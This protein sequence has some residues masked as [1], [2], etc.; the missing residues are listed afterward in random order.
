MTMNCSHV[1]LMVDD[2]NTCFRFYLEKLGLPTRYPPGSSGP[3]AEF[4]LGGDK[5]LGLFDRRLMQEA[6]DASSTRALGPSDDRIALCFEV[7]DVDVEAARLAGLGVEISVPP[8][9][10]VPWGMRTTYVR[11]PAGNLIEL[12]SGLKG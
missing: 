4:A 2:F 7:A 11:D 8:R 3:Y 1:R 6:L 10:H 9:D 12:Y 5:Y